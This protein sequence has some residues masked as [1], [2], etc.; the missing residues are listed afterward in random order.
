[1]KNNALLAA[2]VLLTASLSSKE[3]AFGIIA[4]ILE[5]PDLA[6]LVFW[7]CPEVISWSTWVVPVVLVLVRSAFGDGR[8]V[9]FV[10]L[11]AAMW[12]TKIF[13]FVAVCS[14]HAK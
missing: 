7:T 12:F 6:G 11:H 14:G 2:S 3:W 9:V 1:M 10:V 8:L 5:L 4:K 13:V